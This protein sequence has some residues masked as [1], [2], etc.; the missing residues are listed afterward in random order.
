MRVT[1]FLGL[2]VG[3]NDESHSSSYKEEEFCSDLSH[4]LLKIMR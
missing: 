3:L 4:F 1:G 2:L